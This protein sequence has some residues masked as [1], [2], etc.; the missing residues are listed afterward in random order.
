MVSIEKIA[1]NYGVVLYVIIK[2]DKWC[3][4]NGE[5]KYINKSWS[6][7][8]EI[9][10][11]IYEDEEL[12]TLSFFHEL[13]HVFNQKIDYTTIYQ[14]EKAIWDIAFSIANKFDYIFS[15]KAREWSYKQLET[16]LE[17]SQG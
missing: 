1:E 14:M 6:T 8:N 15:T 10:L 11:G 12:K 9:W 17:K 4:M 2:G 16:Y 13:G 7:A 3:E 5:D